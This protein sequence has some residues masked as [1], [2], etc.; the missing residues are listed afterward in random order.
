MMRVGLIGPILLT[1]LTACSPLRKQYKFAA[2]ELHFSL[3]MVESDVRLAFPINKTKI[4][5]K[6]T[7][8]VENPTTTKFVVRDFNGRLYL[9][10]CGKCL[11]MGNIKLLKSAKLPANGKTNLI[12]ITSVD[13]KDLTSNW[14]LVNMALDKKIQGNWELSGTIRGSI[15]NIPVSLPIQ[16]NQSL[17]H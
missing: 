4:V 12:I 6:L 8:E 16:V 14:A 13:Y 5:S 17:L 2:S 1:I 9:N 3:A 11:N 7:I 10:T 15:Y